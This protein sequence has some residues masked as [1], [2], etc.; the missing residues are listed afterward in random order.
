MVE[1]FT[2]YGDAY[3]ELMA[4]LSSAPPAFAPTVLRTIAA[5]VERREGVAGVEALA[6]KRDLL[7][8]RLLR[9]CRPGGG[10]H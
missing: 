6:R 9:A 7:V 1:Y 4:D 3:R 2:R 10:S 5:A 8:K